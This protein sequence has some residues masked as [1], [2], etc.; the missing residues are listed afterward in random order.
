MNKISAA[1]RGP[2]GGRL[3]PLMPHIDI[4]VSCF[5]GVSRSGKSWLG[6]CTPEFLPTDENITNPPVR[7]GI[8]EINA[9]KYCEFRNS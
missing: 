4:T 7:T 6:N 9:F 8:R 2:P 3:V 5:Y 1:L